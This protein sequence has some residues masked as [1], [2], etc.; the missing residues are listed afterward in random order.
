MIIYINIKLPIIH[1]FTTTSSAGRFGVGGTTY[2]LTIPSLVTKLCTLFEVIKYVCRGGLRRRKKEETAAGSGEGRNR[3][4]GG[5]ERR[6]K[7]EGRRGK[8]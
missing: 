7:E 5:E 3:V 8:S 4:A 1:A 6:K 2:N